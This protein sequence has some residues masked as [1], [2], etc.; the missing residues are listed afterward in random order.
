[1]KKCEICGKQNNL[2]KHITNYKTGESITVCKKCH[3]NIHTRK[4]HELKPKGKKIKTT[5]GENNKP[6]QIK[7]RSDKEN[8]ANWK[9][10][11]NKHN[12]TYNKLVTALLEL[13]KREKHTLNKIIKE[14]NE[15]NYTHSDIRTT[16]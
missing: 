3:V 12:V 4:E 14:M 1:M 15:V 7:I 8:R 13:S 10:L 2:E 16:R 5:I 9:A 11:S 6:V